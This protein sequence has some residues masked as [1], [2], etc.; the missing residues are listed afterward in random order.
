MAI[1]VVRV[2]L[3]SLLLHTGTLAEE[4]PVAFD[5][6]ALFVPLSEVCTRNCKLGLGHD[7]NDGTIYTFIRVMP[8]AVAEDKVAAFE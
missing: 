4:K 3:S 5:P 8:R 1:L 2:L 7:T 6:A